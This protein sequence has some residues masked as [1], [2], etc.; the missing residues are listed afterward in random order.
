MTRGTPST[1]H[2]P[3]NKS[4]ELWLGEKAK[5]L[6]HGFVRLVD[7]MGDDAAIVQAAR[8]S[9]GAGTKSTREDAALIEYLLANAH[10]TPFEMCEIKFHAKMPIFVARQWVRHR[11]ASINEYSMRYS[12]APKEQFVPDL[13][14]IGEQSKTNR[15]GRAEAL[16]T[17]TAMMFQEQLKGS[18]AGAQSLYETFLEKGIARELA[19]VVLPLSSYTEW[20]WKTDLHN[21]LHFLQ[22]RTDPHAQP[23][24]QEYANVIAN[25]TQDWVPMT[26]Q[27][28]ENH[29]LNAV[30]L[31]KKAANALA[32]IFMDEPDPEKGLSRTEREQIERFKRTTGLRKPTNG[33]DKGPGDK[34]SAGAA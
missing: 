5:C 20:Y 3:T 10:T 22:L 8:V 27:A 7:Y 19:R 26:W 30:K 32:G 9:Y 25:I 1:T 15:Q 28:F 31:S 16:D 24:I 23:E 29:R 34:G 4:L 17:E 33:K 2:R 6:D 12:V 13:S 11:T 21:L 14:A 18:A